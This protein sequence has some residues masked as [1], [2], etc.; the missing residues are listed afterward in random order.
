VTIL[1][2]WSGITTVGI[3][4]AFVGVVSGNPSLADYYAFYAAPLLIGASAYLLYVR[5]SAVCFTF[6]LLPPVYVVV[7]L[8]FHPEMTDP[9]GRPVEANYFSLLPLP[10]QIGVA[11]F[12]A[13]FVY[14][15]WLRKTGYF[16]Q[17]Q[18]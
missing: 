18:S 5:S 13:C 9:I 6:A 4:L 12:L 8:H 1:V 10:F 3:T 15:L 14:S 11:F 7:A 17:K 2:L 16:F